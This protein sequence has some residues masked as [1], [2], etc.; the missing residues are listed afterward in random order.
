MSFGDWLAVKRVMER[1]ERAML[2]H[3]RREHRRKLPNWGQRLSQSV[4]RWLVA[5]GGHVVRIGLPPYRS[6]EGEL[7]RRH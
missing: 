7:A 3:F 5:L 6:V 2:D 1:R 4:G